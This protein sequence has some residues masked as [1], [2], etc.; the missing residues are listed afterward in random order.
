MAMLLFIV[1]SVNALLF[2]GLAIWAWR[3]RRRDPSPRVRLLAGAFVIVSI[4]FVLGAVT[5]LLGVAVTLGWL[6]G[7]VRDILVSEWHL[8]QSLGAS[9]LAI[10][11]V[12]MIRRHAASLRTADRIASAVSDKLLEGTS[13]TEFGFTTREVEVLRVIS[14]GH[15]SD[16]EIAQ[17][18]FIAPA[19]AGTHVKN[20]LKKT[21]VGSRR[22]LYLLVASTSL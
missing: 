4:A 20:I 1:I 9:G 18:L 19:T 6:D 11:A 8:L 7:R 16:S 3:S 21:G 10:L 15:M 22:E 5:R 17:I 13:L 14:E 2:V 12:V